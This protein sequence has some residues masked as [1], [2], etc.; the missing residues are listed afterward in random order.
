MMEPTVSDSQADLKKDAC[1][2]S[3]WIMKSRIKRERGRDGQED[4][5]PVGHGEADVHQGPGS[6]EHQGSCRELQNAP[7][8][9][10]ALVAGEA[11]GPGWRR[12]HC[13]NMA[14]G[15]PGS[16]G[17]PSTGPR[18]ARPPHRIRPLP[19]SRPPV[20]STDRHP[21]GSPP[22]AVLPGSARPLAT[23]RHPRRSAPPAANP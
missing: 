17:V 12:S 7:E 3:C 6:R 19:W 21:P 23:R 20:P 18:S 14:G 4:S 22:G 9:V 11:G 5:Q 10:R 16:K 13:L 2:Q 8:K 1:P 15:T